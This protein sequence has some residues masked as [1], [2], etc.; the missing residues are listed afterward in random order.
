[1]CVGNVSVVMNWQ[2]NACSGSDFV[3]VNR[4]REFI[5]HGVEQWKCIINW[6]LCERSVCYRLSSGL[7]AP[8]SSGFP[9]LL[10]FPGV[11]GFS[12]SASPAG[13]L[14]GLHNPT[15]PS[16]LLQ[17]HTH[18]RTVFECL[19]DKALLLQKHHSSLSCCRLIPHLLWRALLLSLTASPTMLQ[20]QE[21]PSLS[22]QACTPSWVGSESHNTL[23][24]KESTLNLLTLIVP[25]PTPQL[26]TLRSTGQIGEVIYR[27]CY[28][29]SDSSLRGTLL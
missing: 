3:T 19:F 25:C 13:P 11:P 8:G 7:Q 23:L 28:R 5:Q 1:M 12:P 10:S 9:S 22:N 16:A 17:V 15:M 6:M 4:K 29:Q 20:P 24:K 14:S 18:A 21:T 2:Q 27:V 26:W